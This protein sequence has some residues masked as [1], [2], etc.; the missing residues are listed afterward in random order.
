M[1]LS[2]RTGNVR[3]FTEVRD[4]DNGAGTTL[5]VGVTTYSSLEDGDQE[6]KTSYIEIGGRSD[7]LCDAIDKLR[8]NESPVRRVSMA[9]ADDQRYV[10][11]PSQNTLSVETVDVEAVSA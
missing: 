9:T 3:P 10:G 5:Q 1:A 7:H 6:Y 11:T 4:Y 8:G 2:I